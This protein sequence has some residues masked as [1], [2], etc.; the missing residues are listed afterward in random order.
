MGRKSL[1]FIDLCVFLT[2]ITLYTRKYF[3]FSNVFLNNKNQVLSSNYESADSFVRLTGNETENII[4][5]GKL[6]HPT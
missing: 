1:F 4:M 3:V 5:E 6:D 2:L